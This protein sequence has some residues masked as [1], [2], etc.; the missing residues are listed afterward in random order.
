MFLLQPVPDGPVQRLRLFLLGFSLPSF[1]PG[2]VSSFSMVGL[3]WVVCSFLVRVGRGLF[4]VARPAL[5]RL[6]RLLGMGAFPWASSMGLPCC[7]LVGVRGLSCAM[8]LRHVSPVGAYGTGR[9]RGWIFGGAWVSL[10][11]AGPCWFRVPDPSCTLSFRVSRLGAACPSGS[12][13]QAMCPH[14]QHALARA[15]AMSE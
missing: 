4:P 15:A 7:L 5:G 10:P 3:G 8:H 14:L 13:F 6:G 2:G 1:P 11:S 9:A 12:R